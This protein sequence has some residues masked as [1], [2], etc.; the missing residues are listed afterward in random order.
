ML[1][2]KYSKYANPFNK[3]R[4]EVKSNRL[5]KICR[6]LYEDDKLVSP[7]FLASYIYSPPVST[8]IFINY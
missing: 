4:D 8:I 1:L 2:D 5:V 6:G 3:I 7:M